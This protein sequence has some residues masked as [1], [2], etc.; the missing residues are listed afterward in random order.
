LF[1]LSNGP[2]LRVVVLNKHNP[3]YMLTNI[4]SMTKIE[5]TEKIK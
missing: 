1:L 3:L 5:N 2:K 4:N